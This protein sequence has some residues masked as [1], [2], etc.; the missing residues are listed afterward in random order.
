GGRHV[1]SSQRPNDVC[2]FE[3]LELLCLSGPMMQWFLV[4]REVPV[5]AE[6]SRLPLPRNQPREALHTGQTGPGYKGCPAVQPSRGKWLA[7][8]FPSRPPPASTAARWPARTQPGTVQTRLR[9]FPSVCDPH[10]TTPAS[11]LPYGLLPSCLVPVMG[12]S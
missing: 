5:S 1:D 8:S 2:G 4:P 6:P 11:E 7:L 9:P 3:P 12:L 10:P